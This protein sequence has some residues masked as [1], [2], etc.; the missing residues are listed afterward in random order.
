VDKREIKRIVGTIAWDNITGQELTGRLRGRG[1][2]FEL[3]EVGTMIL[4]MAKLKDAI[5]G[6]LMIGEGSSAIESNAVERDF[7]HFARSPPHVGF[8]SSPVGLIT[9]TEN[10]TET[11]IRELHWPE[12]LA[13]SNFERVLMTAGPILDGD[14]AMIGFRKDEGEP[15]SREPTIGKPLM[16]MMG[17]QLLLQNLWEMQLLHHAEKQGNIIHT[18]VL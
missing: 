7:I 2:E 10:N 8:E 13:E 16:E 6:D 11:I 15:D 1:H 4:T 5:S 12:R 3:R 18:F 17:A 14:F 9:A